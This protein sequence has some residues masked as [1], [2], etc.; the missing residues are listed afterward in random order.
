MRLFLNFFFALALVLG[1]GGAELRGEARPQPCGCCETSIPGEPCGCG[2]PQ[3]SSQRCGG[4]QAPAS[5]ALVRPA[6]A[7]V[8]IP[9]AGQGIRREAEPCPA[10]L[11][12]LPSPGRKLER[13]PG[14]AFPPGEGPP[15][16]ASRRQALLSLYRI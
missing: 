12:E 11:A 13:V 6:T 1:T 15:D 14:A 5:T 8:E 3:P 9:V 16:S 2:M 7:P 10:D 4:N